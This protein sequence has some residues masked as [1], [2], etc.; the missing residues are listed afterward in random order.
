MQRYPYLLLLLPLLFAL[1]CNRAVGQPDGPATENPAPAA[2]P[3]L[4]PTAADTSLL[5]SISG[6]GVSAPAHLF[7]TIHLIPEEDYFLP[8]GLMK[9]FN[10]AAEIVFEIDTRA[11][12]NPAAMM[13]LLG[14]INMRGDT[15]LRDLLPP[16]RYDSVA[17]HFS[18]VGMPMFLLGRMK[19]MFLS[20]LVG[21]D[22]SAMLGGGGGGG[23]GGMK[24]YE[25]EL[26]ELAQDTDKD[27]GGLETIDFQISLF[28][29]IPYR[30]QAEMLYQTVRQHEL[31]EGGE[32]PDQMA[33]MVELYR[34]RAV[35]EMAELIHDETGET[36][37]FGELLLT[38]RNNAWVPQIRQR[39][40]R[41]GATPVL[42]AVGAGHLGGEQGVIALLRRAGFTVEAVYD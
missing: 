22:P 26:T 40:T 30:V 38:R 24:S 12:Q 36:G 23:L 15:T 27:I 33:Q 1:G 2:P 8:A 29:S 14:K 32:A 28:D 13:G 19:P 34:R 6:P 37:R 16:A 9:N 11:M 4:A 18:A 39:I 20:A 42:Y 21:Q 35:A 5:W 7:G 10:D 17:D 25:L 31:A 3:S 41:A